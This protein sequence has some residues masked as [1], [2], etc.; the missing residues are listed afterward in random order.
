VPV[1]FRPRAPIK[2]NTYNTFPASITLLSIKII[3][4]GETLG[5]TE[6]RELQKVS[7]G[8]S[9]TTKLA[10]PKIVNIV[11]NPFMGHSTTITREYSLEWAKSLAKP[12]DFDELVSNGVLEKKGAWYKI[13]LMA[14]LPRHVRD[15]MT[16]YRSDGCAKFAKGTKAAERLVKKLSG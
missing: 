13:P 3:K 14:N 5:E 15:R 8:V 1:R 4:L 11:F 9:P 6:F 7:P 16:E 12:V 10:V 2:S